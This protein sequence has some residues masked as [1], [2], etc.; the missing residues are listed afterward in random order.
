MVE[1]APALFFIY[2]TIVNRDCQGGVIY[3]EGTKTDLV[4]HEEVCLTHVP[5]SMFLHEIL[6]FFSCAWALISSSPWQPDY[7]FFFWKEPTCFAS[8]HPLFA[9]WAQTILINIARILHF[10]VLRTVFAAQ[11]FT[12]P[13]FLCSLQRST[14]AAAWLRAPIAH[15]L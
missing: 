13:A 7:L 3:V 9:D 15:L 11:P 1:K 5:S 8:Q 6:N 10:H 2:I 12:D 4:R 14:Q